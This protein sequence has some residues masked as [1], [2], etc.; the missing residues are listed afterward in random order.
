MVTSQ[1]LE[2]LHVS[3]RKRLIE[4]ADRHPTARQPLL[5]WFSIMK[6]ARFAKPGELLGVFG[7]ADLVGGMRV[8]FDV[9]GNKYR[10]IAD[11]DYKKGR[12][13]VRAVLT[14]DEYVR[15]DVRTLKRKKK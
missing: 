13:Y 14:H 15:I 5:A 2:S 7:S 9:G 12:I 4:F 1:A 3:T 11:V 8:V 6:R 10:L